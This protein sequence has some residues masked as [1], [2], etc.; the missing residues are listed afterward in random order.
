MGSQWAA[1]G[2]VNPGRRVIEWLRTQQLKVDPEWSVQ[3]EGGFAWWPYR[4]KQTIEIVRE[5]EGTDGEVAYHVGVR[6]ELFRDV[7]ESEELLTALNDQLMRRPS[8][9]GP[10]VAGPGASA[11]GNRAPGGNA[12]GL[13][14]LRCLVR[15]HE[16]IAGWMAPI[17]SVAAILQIHEAQSLYHDPGRLPC[18][19]SAA[20]GRGLTVEFPFGGESS[21]CEIRGDAAHPTYGNGL[22]IVQSFPAAVSSTA[23]A[24]ALPSG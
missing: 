19:R 10:V 6:T 23:R 17:L 20:G 5:E 14:S 7:E 24:S 8:M 16:E 4:H 12:P 22:S 2:G 1:G 9:S 18:G 11:A 21:L 3:T 15:V 13:L